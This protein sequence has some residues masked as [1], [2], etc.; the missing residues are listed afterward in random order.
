VTYF[1]ACETCEFKGGPL[2]CHARV[3]GHRAFCGDPKYRA[4]LHRMTTGEE[5]PDDPTPPT[6][7]APDPYPPLGPPPDGRVRVGLICP[8]LVQGGAE[9]WQLALARHTDPKRVAWVG[10][11]VV[12][13]GDVV[14]AGMLAQTGVFMPV[15]RGL[16]AARE[17][18]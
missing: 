17:L 2:T 4:Y 9:T 5:P 13:E 7:R 18:A 8:C 14:D 10:C 12:D 3:V 1:E 6:S 16:A 11:C 15:T